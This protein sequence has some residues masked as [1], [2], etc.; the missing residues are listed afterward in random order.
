M[1]RRRHHDRPTYQRSGRVAWPRF[2]LAALVVFAIARGLGHIWFLLYD[3]G[4]GYWLIP[5]ILL[6]LPLAIVAFIAVAAGHCRN[7]FVAGALGVA[8][9]FVFLFGYF[10]ADLVH[11][12]GW[13]AF[14]RLDRLP[15]FIAHRMATDGVQGANQ[16]LP[17]TEI[18]NYF[19]SAVELLIVSTIVAGLAV[20]RSLNA[21]CE[22][23]HRWM[24]SIAFRS[25]PVV[26]EEIA[27]ALQSGDWSAIP[28]AVG[29][30]RWGSEA[31]WLEFEY[32]PSL[33]Q[34]GHDCSA[35]LTL[36]EFVGVSQHPEELMYQGRLDADELEA[37]ASRIAA[38]SFLRVSAPIASDEH[39]VLRSIE[40]HAG[41][42]AAI[43]RLPDHM[44][45]DTLDRSGKIEL[46]LALIPV[47]ALII[48]IGLTI[49]GLV[50]APWNEPDSP[51]AWLPLFV[52]LMLALPAAFVVWINV[53]WFGLRYVIRKV[54]ETLSR[55]PDALVDSENPNA[56]FVDIVP[57]AQWHQLV[58]DKPTDRGFFLIDRTL[59]RFVFEG[60]KERYVVPMDAVLGCEVEAMLPHTGGW[61]FFAVVLTV[62]YLGDAPASIIGGRRDDEWEI[63]ILP[64]PMRFRRYSA[65]YR[66]ELADSL[67]DDIAASLGRR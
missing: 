59:R 37:L 67:R 32:C 55:R 26:S 29:K 46:C 33:T 56:R 40:R 2:L 50:R 53:D 17:H 9:T 60:L 12:Q 45:G 6:S 1:P 13:P 24:K 49:W 54:R 58:P 43:E 22:S 7:R 5:P 15:D 30:L 25:D 19:Y 36:K 8:A 34:P 21:Y 64:R 44:G 61:N 16:I 48:G 27:D 35:Y 20:Y 31:A 65:A 51:A 52:G 4:L 62:C 38:L 63:P 42:V 39:V 18:Y 11:Q 23:C 57:R 3:A 66:R 47:G 14:W 10:H 28:P 41:R